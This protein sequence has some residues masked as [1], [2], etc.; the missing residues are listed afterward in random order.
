MLHCKYLCSRHFSKSDSTPTEM[1]CLNRV[2]VPYGSDSAAQSLPQPSKPLLHTPFWS[3]V[4]RF[5]SWMWPSCPASHQNLQQDTGALCCNTYSYP[6][7]QSLHFPSNDC[8]PTITN[9]SQYHCS[10]INFFF[11]MLCN[12]KC[13]W[14]R[15]WTYQSSKFF[16][17]A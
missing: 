13:I 5:N 10:E 16:L 6:H 12:Y 17:K 1:V 2:T 7:R 8:S 9:S 15:T 14:W 4:F 11:P 3:F